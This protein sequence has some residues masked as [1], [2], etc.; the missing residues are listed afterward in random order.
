MIVKRKYL[1]V[2]LSSALDAGKRLRRGKG[3]L[4]HYRS[5]HGRMTD[6][7]VASQEASGE[8]NVLEVWRGQLKQGDTIQLADLPKAAPPRYWVWGRLRQGRFLRIV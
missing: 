5:V 4:F 8:L 7:V 6:M 1:A 2:A 3:R